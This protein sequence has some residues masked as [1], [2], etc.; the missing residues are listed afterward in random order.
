MK[1]TI[2]I[3]AWDAA[4]IALAVHS[5]HNESGLGGATLAMA[6]VTVVLHVLVFWP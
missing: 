2:P 5:I 1:R 4:M 3:L 6:V